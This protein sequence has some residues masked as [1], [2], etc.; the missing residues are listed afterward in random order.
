MDDVFER[1]SKVMRR[2]MSGEALSILT[3]DDRRQIRKSIHGA[4]AKCYPPIPKTLAELHT[5]LMD[6]DTRTKLKE[7]FL[8]V[9][10]EAA[11]MV[12]FS[13]AKNMAFMATCDTLLMDGTFES[14]PT[15]FSQLFIVHAQKN[16]TIVPVAYCLLTSKTVNAYTDAF[17]KLK[18]FL[19]T[20]YEPRRSIHTAVKKI[21]PS[22]DVRGCRFHL[23]QSWFRRIQSLGLT[24]LYISK[25][26]E[27]SFLR[28]FFGLSFFKPD[29]M[30]DFFIED[31]MSLQPPNNDKV[32]EFCEYVHDTYISSTAKFPP[33]MWAQYAANVHHTT[34]AC[35]SMHS[36]LNGMFYHSHPHIFLLLDA[37]MEIQE[38]SYSKMLSVNLTKELKRSRDRQT[39]IQNTIDDFE[40]ETIT[41]LEYIKIL[42]RKYLPGR[43]H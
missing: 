17:R 13:T 7:H 36:H 33:S 16:H 37:L 35:E 18:S 25:S 31:L 1:P 2:E 40:S 15:L 27:G 3:E 12:I 42:S 6:Y 9:N 14:V 43:K 29:E 34:N 21:W 10:D 41:A 4:R 20:E 30:E 24:R 32:R 28:S 19:Q 8:L 22:A 11:N 39:F 5:A 26:S 23:G 38:H